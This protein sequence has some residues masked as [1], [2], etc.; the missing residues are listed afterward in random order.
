MVYYVYRDAVNQW[1][2]FLSAANNRKIANSGEGY[3]NR[4]DCINA[5]NLV[6]GSG[7]TPIRDI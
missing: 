1:R 2:W 3:Y 6:A 7:G 4:Q 5:I